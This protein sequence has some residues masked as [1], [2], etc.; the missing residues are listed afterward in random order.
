M[1]LRNYQKEAAEKAVAAAKKH[2]NTLVVAPTG[3]GKTIIMA[4]IAAKNGGKVCVLQHRE[5][6]VR[7][8]CAK[9]SLVN[10]DMTTSLYTASEKDFSGQATFAMVQTLSRNKG[11]IPYL[12]A[13]LIDEAHHA[14]AATWKAVVEAAKAKN[15]ELRVYGVTATAARGDKKGLLDVFDNCSYYISLRSL[16]EGGCLVSPRLFTLTLGDGIDEKLAQLLPNS[17]G[18]F[19]MEEADCVMNTQACN[20]TV[21]GEWRRLAYSRKTIFFCS[22][23]GHAQAVC[24]VFRAGGVNAR[25]V[26]GSMSIAERVAILEG[27]DQGDIQVLF[28]CAVLTEGYDSQPV[29]CI[30]LLRPCSQK[31]TMIQMIGRGLRRVDPAIY[32]NI[33][34]SDCLVLDFGNSLDAHGLD[35]MLGVQLKPVKVRCSECGKWIQAGANPCPLCGADRTPEQNTG[36]AKGASEKV[37][38]NLAERQFYIESPFS[39]FPLW[40]SEKIRVASGFNSFCAVLTL[41]GERWL[42]LGRKSDDSKVEILGRGAKVACLGAADDFFRMNE[43]ADTVGKK[44]G[45]LAQP[46]TDSQWAILAK[47]GAQ[48]IARLS[49]NKYEAN[50]MIGWIFNR[51]KIEGIL[52]NERI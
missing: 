26:T 42:A 34:K 11:N 43:D 23:V 10:P 33:V 31:P 18:E 22:T 39:W 44:K 14:A 6:L 38:G 3:A 5:E 24:A 9:F 37:N 13:L 7:Q 21:L 17:S 40:G 16:I 35:L 32:P 20:E 45:W 8:N 46:C 51:N 52:R 25:V 41:D 15:P 30:G 47:Y 50:C 49:W 29:S 19:D 2:G 28:N 4:A 48:E 1:I 36:G 27:F 12:D